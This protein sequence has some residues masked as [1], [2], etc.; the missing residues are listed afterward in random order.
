MN[1]AYLFYDEKVLY[2]VT[3]FTGMNLSE[4]LPDLDSIFSS[5]EL[6][7]ELKGDPNFRFLIQSG[8]EHMKRVER[9]QTQE[10]RM[11]T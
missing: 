10:E 7:E 5:E 6:G 2:F 3:F 9:N 11:E 8:Y 1:V 4:I